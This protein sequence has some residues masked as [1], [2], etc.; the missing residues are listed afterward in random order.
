[1]LD[2]AATPWHGPEEPVVVV[3]AEVLVV[4]D[5]VGVVA[6]VVVVPEEVWVELV[7]GVE[8][9]ADVDVAEL[10]VVVVTVELPSPTMNAPVP[11][12]SSWIVVPEIFAPLSYTCFAPA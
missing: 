6:V 10:L 4:V 8:V 9:L 11:V 5:V 3:V 12:L 7:A 2:Q 1:M